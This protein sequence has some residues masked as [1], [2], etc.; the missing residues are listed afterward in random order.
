VYFYEFL[1]FLALQTLFKGSYSFDV[2]TSNVYT[3]NY[4][5]ATM[6][7]P[8]T[9]APTAT[10]NNAKRKSVG[11]GD[12]NSDATWSNT[13]ASSTTALV[14]SHANASSKRKSHD[15]P[16]AKPKRLD[17]PVAESVPIANEPESEPK[18]VASVEEE[19][20]ASEASDQAGAR[21]EDDSSESASSTYSYDGLTLP[22]TLSG[23][24]PL[25]SPPN[26]RASDWVSLPSLPAIPQTPS[27]PS[28]SKEATR[29]ASSPSLASESEEGFA[30][31][32]DMLDEIKVNVL[33]LANR[34]VLGWFCCLIDCLFACLVGWFVLFI[35][36]L[37]IRSLLGILPAQSS[38]D[39]VPFVATL[40]TLR[41]ASTNSINFVYFLFVFVYIETLYFLLRSVSVLSVS[42]SGA[43]ARE[44]PRA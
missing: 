40:K 30:A 23:I 1:L 33:S 32:A 3:S 11:S 35:G 27:V 14:P 34:M 19:N 26:A 39:L 43:G 20:E 2:N 24:P 6:C 7:N 15:R 8:C 44:A 42:C 21:A 17:L 36:L 31:M 22:R 28:K 41:Q 10:S 9:K 18:R 5:N 25:P 37:P 38:T 29:S 13:N 12:R 16:N 4:S